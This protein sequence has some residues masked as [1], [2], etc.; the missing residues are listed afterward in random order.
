[1]LS[2]TGLGGLGSYSGVP[3]PGLTYKIKGGWNIMQVELA[4]QIR[5][6]NIQKKI[7]EHIDLFSYNTMVT[8]YG[9]RYPI[10]F[11]GLYYVSRV[12]VWFIC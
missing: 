11:F 10:E 8:Y 3:G 12:G 7:S 9:L 4:V 5:G 2:S 1:M 6:K